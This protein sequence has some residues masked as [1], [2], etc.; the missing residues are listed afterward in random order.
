MTSTDLLEAQL[1]TI[2]NGNDTLK[3]FISVTE[4]TARREAEVADAAA[5]DGRWLGPLHGMTV[6]LKDNIDTAGH[7]TTAGAAFYRGRVP[8]RDATVVR[9]LRQ[10]GAVI[11]GKANLT[12]LAWGTRGTSAV[13]GQTRNPWNTDHIPGGSSAGSGAS[14]AAGMCTASLGTDTGGS[15]RLP[16]SLCGVSGLRPTSGSVPNTGTIP[17]SRAHDTVGPVAR[18][19]EDVAR[20]FSVI[21]GH[22]PEDPYSR[23]HVYPNFLPTIH[24]GVAGKTIGIPRNH[25]FDRCDDEVAEAVRWAAAHLERQGARLVDVDVPMV[26]DAQEMATRIVFSDACSFHGETLRNRPESFSPEIYER[27]I[28]G[29]AFTGTDYAEAMTFKVAWKHALRTL[30]STVDILLSP[31]APVAAPLIE[32]GKSLY[33]STRDLVRNTYCGALGNIPGLS[34]PCG[35]TRAGLPIGLQL[36]AAWWQEPLLFQ[37]GCAFQADTDFHRQTPDASCCAS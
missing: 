16:A 26:E 23:P 28:R 19:V 17:V 6:S 32:D 20:L 9:R 7:E 8:N 22:D 11:I 4:A 14:V 12:E 18:H 13:G 15:V 1:E 33:D 5:A 27:M 10:G 2:A 21:A 29:F 24:D 36:E 31:T 30:F 25:Y 35:S 3:A 34:V 37:A